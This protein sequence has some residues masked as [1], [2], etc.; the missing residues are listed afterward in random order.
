[1][2]KLVRRALTEEAPAAPQPREHWQTTQTRVR[3][4]E[5]GEWADE[6]GLDEILDQDPMQ[7]RQRPTLSPPAM[8]GWSAGIHARTLMPE[9]PLETQRSGM[10]GWWNEVERGSDESREEAGGEE[11]VRKVEN[12][13]LDPTQFQAGLIGKRAEAWKELFRAIDASGK[14]GSEGFMKQRDTKLVLGILER[15]YEPPMRPIAEARARP[16]AEGPGFLKKLRQVTQMVSQAVGAQR[17]EELLSGSRPGRIHFGNRKSVDENKQFVKAEIESMLQSGAV[18][19]WEELAAEHGLAASPTV[20][21]PLGVVTREVDGKIK[22]RLVLDIRYPNIFMKHLPFKFEKLSQIFEFLKKEGWI[23]VS[24]FKSG[25]HHV[26]MD[27]SAFEYMAFEFE[28]EVFGFVVMPFGLKPAVHVFDVLAKKVYQCARML[29][30]QLCFYIDDR[31]SAYASRGAARWR[32]EMLRKLFTLL[33]WYHALDKGLLEPQQEGPYL[34]F[35]IDSVRERIRVRDSKISELTRLIETALNAGATA[36]EYARIAGKLLAM[37]PAIGLAPLFTQELYRVVALSESWEAQG[38]PTEVLTQDLR[39]LRENLPQMNG[40][41]WFLP[42]LALRIKGDASDTGSGAHVDTR[43]GEESL[44]GPVEDM[45]WSLTPEEAEAGLSSTLR[46][47]MA[48]KNTVLYLLAGERRKELKDRLLT[49]VS[50]NQGL[51]SGCNRM[52][53]RVPALAECYRSVWLECSKAGVHLKLEW[54][55]RE[56]NWR[57]DELSKIPDPSAWGLPKLE[58]QR[59]CTALK[60]GAAA[61]P[62]AIL[63]RPAPTWDAFADEVNTQCEYFCAMHACSGK[64]LVDAFSCGERLRQVPGGGKRAIVWAFPPPEA[65][66]RVIRW[67]EAHRLNVVLVYPTRPDKPW[68][69]KMLWGPGAPT[70]ALPVVAD[71]EVGSRGLVRGTRVPKEIGAGWPRAQL[72]AAL[73]IYDMD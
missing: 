34:G 23:C 14:P 31:F 48:L 2:D 22:R 30:F 20:I 12:F 41:L 54:V 39:Y 67:I 5:I 42:A 16:E 60:L 53:S 17:A 70:D 15:G 57:A 7:Q 13:C 11:W 66:G 36:R 19:R 43:Q 51:V 49:Y 73:V 37:A 65:I 46:E 35:L 69:P 6:E 44:I 24:D 55:P 62:G 68:W 52:F 3:V 47:A 33:G 8:G 45:A 25:Y 21:N 27:P 26:P 18:R 4:V 9:V 50:D 38:R 29:G 10:R 56:Q 59:V 63:R 72:R 32:E 58:Y 64:A 28:G 40:K 1:M 61:D 71:V